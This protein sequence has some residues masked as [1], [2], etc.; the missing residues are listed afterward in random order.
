[1]AHRGAAQVILNIFRH[2][3]TP[4]HYVVLSGDVHYSFVYEVLIRHRQRSPLWQV[5]SSGIKNEFPG[6][7]WMCSTGSTAGCIHRAR[8][9]TGSPSVA[10]WRWC[11]VPSHSK[12]GER[13][14]NGAGLGQVFFDEQGR[15]ER[16]FQLNADGAAATEFVRRE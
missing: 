10:R 11:R 14:W 3:R 16:V 5:T 9:S 4:G 12:A 15:P 13:L 2:S 6:A 7:C 1:M 8:R